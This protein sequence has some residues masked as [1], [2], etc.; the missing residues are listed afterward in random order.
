MQDET[1]PAVLK[2]GV[3]QKRLLPQLGLV[4]HV[5][6]DR[7]STNFRKLLVS[8]AD[9]RAVLARILPATHPLARPPLSS[10]QAAYEYAVSAAALQVG[11]VAVR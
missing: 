9:W 11:D 1:V 7:L 5:C 2:S 4:E 8:E 3:L 6:L 10:K